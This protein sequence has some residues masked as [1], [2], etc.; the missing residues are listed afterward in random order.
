VNLETLN[1]PKWLAAKDDLADYAVVEILKHGGRDP[2]ASLSL[3]LQLLSNQP[4]ELPWP[5]GLRDF[6][7]QVPAPR[8]ADQ[9]RIN[10]AQQ[11]FSTWSMLAQ[12]TL[13]CASLPETYCL[14]ATAQMLIISGQL[15]HHTT[16]RIKMTGQMLLS[17][18]Y[19][20]GIT[21]DSF[22]LKALRRTRLMHAA[23]RAM[24]MTEPKEALRR[25]SS[26]FGE[27][28]NQL[29]MVYTL[30]TFSHVVLR[31]VE[32]LGIVPDRQKCE[33]YIY[34]WNIA[35]RVLGVHPDILPENRVE[36]ELVFDRIKAVHARALPGTPALTQALQE[37]WVRQFNAKHL[38]LAVPIMHSLFQTLLTPATRQLL[39]I[40]F[41]SR[42]VEEVNHLVTPVMETIVRVTDEAFRLLPP[43]ARLAAAVNHLLT[44]SVREEIQDGGLYDTRRHMEA[45][46]EQ[47]SPFAAH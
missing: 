2:I 11:W 8:D 14:P 42:T 29:A 16:R 7:N 9:V 24:L 13:F 22:A 30:M 21:E 1:D 45:W 38:P 43:L 44:I 46:Q 47:V 34:T 4:P 23:V 5:E 37:S 19:P 33:D 17:V 18:M 36:S 40:P 35:G 27:P 3:A 39:G 31:S 26:E 25:W 12:A 41:P 6:V 15:V 28:I 10:S 32:L 20:G